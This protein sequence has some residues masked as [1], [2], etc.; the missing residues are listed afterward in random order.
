MYHVDHR[1]Y[2]KSPSTEQYVRFYLLLGSL[3]FTSIRYTKNLFN[4]LWYT[5]LTLHNHVVLRG[6]LLYDFYLLR[7]VQCHVLR[8]TY[9]SANYSVHSIEDVKF[10]YKDVLH[11]KSLSFN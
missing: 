7:S 5:S 6:N 8:M 4:G 11:V 10:A 3:P 2:L 1:L 9:T